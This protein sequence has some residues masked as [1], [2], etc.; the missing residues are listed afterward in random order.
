MPTRSNA[1]TPGNRAPRPVRGRPATI[2]PREYDGPPCG[3]EYA[4]PNLAA[5]EG[6]GY[7]IGSCAHGAGHKGQHR[8]P[9]G[10]ADGGNVT[11]AED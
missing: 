3:A 11:W 2:A 9:V 4:G 6:A 7:T 5:W 8:A 10:G 1:G